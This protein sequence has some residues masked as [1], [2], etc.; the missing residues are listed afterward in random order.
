M[1]RR[2]VCL[3]VAAGLATLLP[4][5]GQTRD[6]AARELR[7][8]EIAREMAESGELLV[9]TL[10][11]R[12]YAAKPPV[13]HAMIVGLYHLAGG[14]SLALARLP[15]VLAAVAGALALYGLGCVLSGRLTALFAAFA[16]LATFEYRHMA[17]VARPDMV[18]TAAILGSCFA[19]ALA[20]RAGARD[21]RGLRLL[22]AGSLAGL[23]TITKGPLG[24]GIPALFGLSA[25]VRRDDLGRLRI[26]E[27]TTFL[28]GLVGVVGAWAG[29]L[30]LAGHGG[31][32]YRL[33]T[34][35]DL[36]GTDPAPSPGYRYL[37]VLVI[38]FLPFTTV[39]PVV[40]RDVR[41][42]RYTAPV[43]IAVVLLLFL[44]VV[45]KKRPHYL[46][47]VYPFLALAVAEAV[48]DAGARW[49][50]RAT[51]ALAAAV[52]VLGP[53]YYG[54]ALPW[55]LSPEEPKLVMGRRVLALV[56]HDR[57]IVCMDELAEAIAFVGRRGGVSQVTEVSD[58]VREARI[59]G[60]GSYIALPE[61]RASALLRAAAG[62]IDLT[63][64]LAER[65]P[66]HRHER[67][68]RLYRV[69]SVTA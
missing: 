42:R 1:S 54:I 40:V 19:V 34:Q 38:G 4:F 29:C 18:F 55:R 20:L 68:W 60:A 61:D 2:D 48:S 31:Y 12:E 41:R 57:P 13:M 49:I 8:A 33:V 51:M 53:F 9:P 45:P 27:W 26:R 50:R 11:G 62:R 22:A 36:A 56:G 59:N 23:A 67:G 52:L 39:L 10:F 17:R 15:S 46:L 47:P 65:I 5:L 58:V 7:H 28:A 14:P 30:W 66:V 44:S 32:L 63:Q 64:V 3:I 24:A 69:D 16:L 6:I 25:P 35:P 21:G 43:A 37:G